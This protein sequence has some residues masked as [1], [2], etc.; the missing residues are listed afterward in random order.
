M[1]VLEQFFNGDIRA[2]SRVISFVE[3]RESGYRDLLG[4]LY[5]KQRA[6][7]VRIP[8]E[9]DQSFRTKLTTESGGS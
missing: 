8:G 1:T 5:E 7:N 6:R 2:L 4:R 9:V 3:N